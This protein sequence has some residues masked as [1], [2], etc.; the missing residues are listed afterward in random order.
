MAELIYHPDARAEIRDAAGHYEM[1]REGLGDAFLDAVESSI[2]RITQFP[3]AGRVVSD[4]CRRVL[5]RRFPYG[6]IYAIQNDAIF[7]VA[8]MHSKRK[9]GYWKE[10]LQDMR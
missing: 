7:V 3:E 5:L 4:Q 8:L 9:P 6:V 2:Q 1:C 10:R